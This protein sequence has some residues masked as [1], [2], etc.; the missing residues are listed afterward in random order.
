MKIICS[1]KP[2]EQFLVCLIALFTLLTQSWGAELPRAVGTGLQQH[3]LNLQQTTFVWELS[4]ETQHAAMPADEIADNQKQLKK[5]YAARYRRIG[6]TDETQIQKLVQQDLDRFTKA[7][8]QSTTH[9][10]NS[11]RF[12][13]DS[14]SALVSGS[15]QYTSN[16]TYPFRQLY[17]GAEALLAEDTS[18]G[19]PR[20]MS[21]PIVWRT[22]GESIRN[23]PP[24]IQGL[25]L[26]PEHLTLLAG[27]NPLAMHGVQWKLIS[28]TPDTWTLEAQ[29]EHA[30]TP[31]DVQMM[32]DRKHDNVPAE[33]QMIT[34]KASETF[35]AE[36]FRHYQGVWI[37]DKVLYKKDVPGV[38]S[39]TQQWVLQS[40]EPSKPII[41]NLPQGRRVHDYRLMGQDLNWQDIQNADTPN[42]KR[43]VYYSWPGHF[44]SLDELKQIYQK[45]H[46]GEATPD[47]K[48]SASLPFVGGLL[49]LVGGVWMFK[50]RGVS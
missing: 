14:Q 9:Y 25:N 8:K 10:S 31:V 28:T 3:E 27:L 23:F 49:C 5:S 17:D 1:V 19:Q 45:Q 42:S 16:T 50:R 29:I 40:L 46:P 4:D 35:T 33:I 7:M 18:A 30:N 22:S 39:A 44:L 43:L 32:L 34:G 26:S 36:S 20:L 41:V 48:S 47:P 12:V 38:V 11:W 6:M 21:A 2:H 37:C 24:I 15:V 13:R